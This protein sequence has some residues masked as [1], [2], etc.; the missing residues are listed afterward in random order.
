[1][2]IRATD[3]K[4]TVHYDELTKAIKWIDHVIDFSDSDIDM[5]ESIIND[6]SQQADLDKEQMNWLKILL[7]KAKTKN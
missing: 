7:L 4:G 3:P 6:Q 2:C 5:L 1:M